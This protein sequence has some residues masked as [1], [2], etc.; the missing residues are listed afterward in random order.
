[1]VADSPARASSEYRAFA[2]PIWQVFIYFHSCLDLGKGKVAGLGSW[3]Q[4]EVP[5]AGVQFT[6]LLLGTNHPHIT[7]FRRDQP[8][9]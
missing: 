5:R 9:I 8:D 1:M 4:V 3:A 6:T 2:F 7:F